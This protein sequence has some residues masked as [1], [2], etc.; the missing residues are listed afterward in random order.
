[1]KLPT[2]SEVIDNAITF[3]S[4]LIGALI[5]YVAVAWPS[6]QWRNPKAN[7]MSFYRDFTSVMTWRRLPEYQR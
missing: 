3:G 7:Q 2:R 6:F 4:L 5:L 1:M